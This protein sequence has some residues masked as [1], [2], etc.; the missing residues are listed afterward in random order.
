[1]V[2]GFNHNL[3]HRS[4]IFHVQTED[5]G[6]AAPEVVTQLFLG[7][8]L[9]AVERWTYAGRLSTSPSHAHIESEVRHQMIS[10]HKSMLKRV[11]TGEFDRFIAEGQ[12]AGRRIP[13]SPSAAARA[14]TEVEMDQDPVISYPEVKASVTKNRISSLPTPPPVG[15]PT[16][17]A[18]LLAEIDAELRRQEDA[19]RN[20]VISRRPPFRTPPQPAASPPRPSSGQRRGMIQYADTI[21][22]HV[23]PGPDS[24]NHS[25]DQ[26]SEIKASTPEQTQRPS[27]P[28]QAE[29]HIPHEPASARVRRPSNVRVGGE[30]VIQPPVLLTSSSDDIS[31]DR[32]LSLEEVI[33]AYLLEKD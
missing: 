21:P 17:D 2:P 3:R 8:Q 14:L 7:G 6:R 19:W 24:E 23:P 13:R 16:I 15:T 9:L 11:T 10:Q 33:Q 26:S 32:D 28:S 22:D 29:R 12:R 25:L 5:G 27:Y 31:D 20:R 18:D 1:M 4:C 30:P